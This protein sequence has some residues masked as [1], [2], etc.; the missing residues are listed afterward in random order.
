MA[1]VITQEM[2]EQQQRLFE[3]QTELMLEMSEQIKKDVTEHRQT[4][5]LIKQLIDRIE[6]LE[7]QRQIM[8]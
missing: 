3:R 1:H 2:Y 4:L 7:T 6:R 8:N 5:M